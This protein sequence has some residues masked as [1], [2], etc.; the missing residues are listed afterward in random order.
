M[1]AG[2][3]FE[4]RYPELAKAE[5]EINQHKMM[6]N[7]GGSILSQFEAAG[8]DENDTYA[9]DTFFEPYTVQDIKCFYVAKEYYEGLKIGN[10]RTT[11]PST[12]PV[13]TQTP[14]NSSVPTQPA[15]QS[16]IPASS[17]DLRDVLDIWVEH[18]FVTKEGDEKWAIST[19]NKM[20]QQVGTMIDMVGNPLAHEFTDLILRDLYAVNI[21]KLP[22]NYKSNPLFIKKKVKGEDGKIVTVLKP[23]D[24]IFRIVKEKKIVPLAKST[25]QNYVRNAISF[26]IWAGKLKYLMKH[27]DDVLEHLTNIAG[28]DNRRKL[29]EENELKALF[30]TKEYKEGLL[31]KYPYR[32][33]VILI[34]LYTGCRLG[35]A[36]QLFVDDICFVEKESESS[37]T[38]EFT[39]EGEGQTVKSKKKRLVP[40][41]QDLIDLGLLK[42]WGQQKEKGENQLFSIL[43]PD[44]NGHWGIHVS[45]W[46][47]AIDRN[48]VTRMCPIF[49]YLQS[50]ERGAELCYV[51]LSA[52]QQSDR[53]TSRLVSLFR[54]I[55]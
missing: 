14:L 4:K 19:R 43:K 51:T 8:I 28:E 3:F 15:I 6:V 31:F 55:A 54:E 52:T 7:R 35:E 30:E 44:N 25:I 16:T 45:R 50:A 10:S 20:A 39:N 47:K 49:V 48:I 21:T 29:Y 34:Q 42:Y 23:Y 40:I 46:F 5:N 11:T 22:P 24:E 36:S 38:F 26:L 53:K 17:L 37:W 13:A 18:N 1:M 9:M 32:H 33:W 41:D 27:L 12:A 2:D